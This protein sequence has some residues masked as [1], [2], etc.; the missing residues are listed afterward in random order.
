MGFI[1]QSNTKKIYAYLTQYARQQILDGDEKDFTVKYFSL[2]D[3]DVNYNISANI[4]NNSYNTLPSGFIPDI[5]GDNQGCLLSIA[6]GIQIENSLG[7]FVEPPP[8]VSLSAT[9]TSSCELGGSNPVFEPVRTGNF[10]IKVANIQGGTGQGFYWYVKTDVISFPTAT[11]SIEDASILSTTTSDDY[12]EGEEVK[13]NATFKHS[14]NG[15]LPRVAD[16]Y[17]FTVYAGDSSGNEVIIQ[18]FKDI[19]CSK[20][21]FG[22]VANYTT[23]GPF[24]AV[25]G[26]TQENLITENQ[27]SNIDYISDNKISFALFVVDN[28]NR[29][30]DLILTNADRQEYEIEGDDVAINIK[31]PFNSTNYSRD[32]SYS[33]PFNTLISTVGETDGYHS[34]SKLIKGAI[35]SVKENWLDQMGLYL[36]PEALFA[37]IKVIIDNTSNFKYDVL[38]P[39]VKP[40]DNMVSQG[41][42]IAY[43]ELALKI[44]PEY[45]NGFKSNTFIF[46]DALEFLYPFTITPNPEQVGW[47]GYDAYF[48][49]SF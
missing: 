38:H 19:N 44:D 24:D 30:R 26:Y 6:N 31:N 8:P 33:I 20:R 48:S 41:F 39:T 12:I 3:T 4:V 21:T 2:H 23:G 49:W 35:S 13:F 46:V 47:S 7:G 18:E 16:S 28:G 14:D 25:Q 29:R 43:I 42:E 45:A 1:Q 22:V 5:T 11:S 37:S 10:N 27:L 40:F 15:Y 34:Q 17:N 32:N 9:V 36:I